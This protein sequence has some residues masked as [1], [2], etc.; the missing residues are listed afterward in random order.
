M[1]NKQFIW[2]IGL[3]LAALLLSGCGTTA[4]EQTAMTPTPAPTLD[5]PTSTARP[6][7][8]IPNATNTPVS[9]TRTPAPTNTI[10]SPTDTPV[11]PTPDVNADWLEYFNAELGYSFKY[12]AGCSFGPVAADC[13]QSPPEERPLECLCSLNAEDPNVVSLESFLGNPEEGLTGVPFIVQ[14]YDTP[15][16][17]PP[18]GEEWIPWINKNYSFLSED[19][20]DEPNLTL[21]GLPAVRI[22]TPGS[23]QAYA[24]ENIFVLKEG[25]LIKI[26]MIDVD[27]EEHREYFENILATFQF[28]EYSP[29]I[30]S[31]SDTLLWPL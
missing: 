9:I 21:G 19:I 8:P 13:K 7:T 20:P 28:S 1:K 12:P 10:A 2:G 15:A 11:A 5:P 24:A 27:V 3:T 26:Y 31:I 30:Q 23:P 22:Y 14:H 25:K 6:S 16:Y 29:E 4:T 17:N 18:E